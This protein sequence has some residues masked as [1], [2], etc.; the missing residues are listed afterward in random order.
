M[1]RTAPLM[2]LAVAVAIAG[3]L[4]ARADESDGWRTETRPAPPPRVVTPRGPIDMRLPTGLIENGV[5]FSVER[6]LAAP[7]TDE[8]GRFLVLR[9][10]AAP[11]S[12]V[13]YGAGLGVEPTA[14]GEEEP[15][16]AGRL[17]G[18]V[19]APFSNT[20]DVY[21]ELQHQRSLEDGGVDNRVQF[22]L[23]RRF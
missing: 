8:G 1:M 2:R 21:G 19:A 16:L 7:P 22:G 15:G 9:R 11:G 4:A 23:R 12:A 14:P 17:V 5:S 3:G 18:G 20:M 13:Y 10:G 6:D